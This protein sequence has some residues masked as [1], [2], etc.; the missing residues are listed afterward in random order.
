[1]AIDRLAVDLTVTNDTQANQRV[2]SFRKNIE[3]T[4]KKLDD[5][6]KDSSFAGRFDE[7]LAKAEKRHKEFV[8]K[9]KK[10][11]QAA[12]GPA[13]S[14]EAAAGGG[15]LASAAPLIATALL[16]A[17]AAAVAFGQRSI[18]AAREAEKAQADLNDTARQT[19]I[20]YD[21]LSA[22]ATAFAKN[23]GIA[24]TDAAA[25]LAASAN[26]AADAG[27]K[28]QIDAFQTGIA[29]IAAGKKIDPSQIAN[30]TAA[31]ND[32]N[33]KAI[34]KFTDQRP[35]EIFNRFAESIGTTASKL[36][37]AQK[38]AAVFD[39]TIANSTF[40]RG[41]AA[42]ATKSTASAFGELETA[43]GK[44][45]I[46]LDEFLSKALHTATTG[47][48]P[49]GPSPFFVGLDNLIKELSSGSLFND[50]ANGNRGISA[51][52][53][54][55]ASDAE[56][57]K[58]KGI[59]EKIKADFLQNKKD[60][61]A[62][63]SDPASGFQNFALSRFLDQSTFGGLS[64]ADQAAARTK[65]SKDAKEFLKTQQ[66]VFRSEF[67]RADRSELSQGFSAF[68]LLSRAFD[69]KD[70]DE[71]AGRFSDATAKAIRRVL[72]NQNKSVIELRRALTDTLTAPEL[73]A[74]DRDKLAADLNAAI[75]KSI[76]E[77]KKKIAELKKAN[78][79]LFGDL[80]NA[81][82]E[83][84]PFV[85]VFSEAEK[86]IERTRLTTANLS[87]ELRNQA[88]QMTRAANANNLF[89]ARLQATLSAS[90][91]R[92][93]GAAFRDDEGTETA[94]RRAHEAL[95]RFKR[96]QATGLFKNPENLAI[97]QTG[98]ST[99]TRLELFDYQR[100]LEESG[101][102]FRNPDIQDADRRAIAQQTGPT[103][104][105]ARLDRQLAALN[106]LHPENEDQRSQ[107][108]RKIIALTQGVDPKDLTTAERSAAAAARENE[109][110]R[111]EMQEQEAA[112]DR[113]QRNKTLKS[114]DDNLSKLREIAESE[115]L[116]GVIRIINEAEDRAKV[117]L[118]QRPT[119]K[120]TAAKMKK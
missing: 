19:G 51:D 101:G 113:E 21:Q 60:L 5:L 74:G 70:A 11:N 3:G 106:K 64:A 1:M 91:L 63:F 16:T 29:D 52:T 28:G 66:S 78:A 48:T 111:I 45:L 53:F 38:Q 87:D 79:D 118:G 76:D 115:G 15:D 42:N 32:L 109:A 110:T 84:N 72:D 68:K 7:Q 10:Q 34:Q 18:A 17:G 65:A 107:I 73:N 99:K 97:F 20:A 75:K 105:Q 61:A 54:G 59:Q 96:N 24:A 50:N 37:D 89:A 40:F 46:P 44:A 104:L 31:L 67:D 71:I 8:D 26:F 4:S 36:T 55:A 80:F 9:I 22:K 14:D 95:A 100:R 88:E 39:A 98:T 30:I 82:G 94:D 6:G 62:A 41:D 69:P 33:Q 43:I 116:T 83:N 119:S 92:A 27:R 25:A 47:E 103:T 120:D 112:K 114:L 108:D 13:G 85:K 2:D 77:G 102:L 93:E 56:F 86:A 12:A 49:G 35:D 58:W 57:Q 23:T 81:A 117:S 90:D